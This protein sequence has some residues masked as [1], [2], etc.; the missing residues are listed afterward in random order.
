M[1][2]NPGKI[3]IIRN[4]CDKEVMVS[5]DNGATDHFSMDAGDSLIIDL[6]QADLYLTA[7]SVIKAKYA[8]VVPT[9]GKIKASVIF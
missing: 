4:S 1:A 5:L 7:S 9:T 8:S 2:A 3:L 6:D